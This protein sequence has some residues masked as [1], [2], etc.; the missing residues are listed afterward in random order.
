MK[1]NLLYGIN[2]KKKFLKIINYQLKKKNYDLITTQ[3]IR[4]AKLTFDKEV[5]FFY[6]EKSTGKLFV[7]KPIDFSK[8]KYRI[9]TDAS[10]RRKL[11]LKTI[12]HQLKKLNTPDYLFSKSDRDYYKN[13]K[14]HLGNKSIITM[15]L[16]NF[17][18]LCDFDKIYKFALKSGNNGL[19][20]SE[21]V[22]AIFAIITTCNSSKSNKRTL[23]QG[24]P[25]S[26]LLS[27]LSMYDMFNEIHEV[28]L[29]RG[30]RFSCYVDDL[31]FSYKGEIDEQNFIE[32]ISHIVTRNGHKINSTKTR[33]NS[34]LVTGMYLK[35]YKL[36]ASS[37]MHSKLVINYKYCISTP[38]R[39]VDDYFVFWK[40]FNS[41]RG[42]N[43]TLNYV[44]LS[45]HKESKAEIEKYIIKESY[46][47][48]SHLSPKGSYFFGVNK[49]RNQKKIY[50][51]YK[52]ELTGNVVVKN[53]KIE[54]V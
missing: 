33:R 23:A 9:V 1:K 42:V 47:F 31:T 10:D 4:N 45:K 11:V 51:F 13:A 7:N 54:I 8:S 41:L 40:K 19:G 15:D 34:N 2:S 37:K 26:P 53:G 17:F 32:L 39:S 3:N 38:I 48:P 5:K 52:G 50:S 36:R 25:T 6:V 21:D 24:F 49:N 18:D 27:F 35:N 30:V 44:E 12:N 28:S 43:N 16:S 14:Y 20:M 46:K 29:E 22:A